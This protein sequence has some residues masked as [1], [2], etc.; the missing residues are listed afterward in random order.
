MDSQTVDEL[1]D[2]WIDIGDKILDLVDLIRMLHPRFNNTPIEK[3][4]VLL[5]DAYKATGD[6]EES[7]ERGWL[8]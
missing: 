4:V 6:V 8:R 7:D 1:H 2:E 5:S 3:V